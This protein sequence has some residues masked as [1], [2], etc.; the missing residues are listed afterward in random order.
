MAKGVDKRT[1]DS[2]DE[3]MKTKKE[4]I[5]KEEKGVYCESVRRGGR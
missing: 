4:Q 3:I 5:R 2:I 1:I